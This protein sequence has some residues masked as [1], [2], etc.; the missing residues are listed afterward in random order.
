MKKSL[1][2]FYLQFKMKLKF[3]IKDIKDGV[4][5]TATQC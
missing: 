4:G 5:E 1:L 2:D 3:A